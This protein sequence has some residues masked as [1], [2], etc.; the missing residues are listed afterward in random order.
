MLGLLHGRRREAIVPEIQTDPLLVLCAIR[1]R[2]GAGVAYRLQPKRGE[3]YESPKEDKPRQQAQGQA[4]GQTP[5]P[6]RESVV[7]PVP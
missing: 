4:K 7:P 6:A 5:P 2:R 1:H 3:T